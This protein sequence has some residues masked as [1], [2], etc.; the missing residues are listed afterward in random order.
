[1]RNLI[2]SITVAAVAMGV[3]A[4]CQSK[5]PE[6]IE[7]AKYPKRPPLTAEEMAQAEKLTKLPPP[8]ERPK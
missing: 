5:T 6:E 8:E 1:M 4:G 2:G 7:A 3:L